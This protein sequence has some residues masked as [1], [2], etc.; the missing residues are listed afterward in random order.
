[1]TIGLRVPATSA[2]TNM[3]WESTAYVASTIATA[4]SET[5][6]NRGPPISSGRMRSHA[7][8]D[9]QHHGGQRKEELPATRAVIPGCLQPDHQVHDPGAEDEGPGQGE[10]PG[11]GD[12]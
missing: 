8:D 9:P 11:G 6:T 5:P 10:G 2:A 7:A 4:T 3:C 1:M 12:G